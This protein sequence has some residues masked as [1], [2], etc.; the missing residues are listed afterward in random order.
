MTKEEI[1]NEIKSKKEKLTKIQI[2]EYSRIMTEEFT[3]L[4]E[5]K[6]SSQLILYA[7]FNQEV[8]TYPLIEQAL[9]EGKQ[10]ALPRIMGENI[11]FFYVGSLMETRV[12]GLGI[13]EP[14]PLLPVRLLPDG[15]N[16]MLTP[17]L[18]FDLTGNRI[19]YGKSYYDSYFA[20]RKEQ[21]IKIAFAYSFQVAEQIPYEE[22]DV[23]IDL[24]ITEAGSHRFG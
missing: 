17:G 6:E 15:D 16:I 8:D 11:E 4:K 3:S 7:A 18:A 24:L 9:R 19:G 1:R 5:Y 14:D 22:H 21:F 10:V 2:A 23:K 12:S 20:A 13:P